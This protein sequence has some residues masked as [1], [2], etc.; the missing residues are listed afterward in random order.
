[1]TIVQAEDHATPGAGS[2]GTLD[3]YDGDDGRIGIDAVVP[4][5]VAAE[6]VKVAAG[7]GLTGFWLLQP[8]QGGPTSLQAKVPPDALAAVLAPAEAAGVKILDDRDVA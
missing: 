8:D 5:A 1:M 4:Y 6:M 2:I 7:L 3:L